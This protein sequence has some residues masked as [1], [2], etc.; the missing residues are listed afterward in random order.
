MIAIVYSTFILCS[1]YVCLLLHVCKCLWG[2]FVLFCVVLLSFQKSKTHWWGFLKKGS[3][4]LH[5]FISNDGQVENLLL[6]RPSY[7]SYIMEL[8]YFHCF[9]FLCLGVQYELISRHADI[10]VRRGHYVLPSLECLVS[11]RVISVNF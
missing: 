8:N 5:L 11:C 6:R 9:Q 10:H 1:L 2:F 7:S 3:L 4:I